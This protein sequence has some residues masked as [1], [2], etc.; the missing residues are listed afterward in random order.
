MSAKTD[1]DFGSIRVPE[2][3]EHPKRRQNP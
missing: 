2:K 3:S 1:I